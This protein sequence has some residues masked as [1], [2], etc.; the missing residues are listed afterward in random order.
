MTA[1]NRDHGTD[2][3]MPR[4]VTTSL[5]KLTET[6][7]EPDSPLFDRVDSIIEQGRAFVAAQ[8]NL[9]HTLTFW[10]V[11]H[12]INEDVLRH[13][14]ADYGKQVVETLSRQ[15]VAKRG[16]S[17]E[18]R[19]LRRMIQFARTFPNEQIVTSLMTQLSWTH[20]LQLLPLKTDEARLFYAEHAI[21]NHLNVR[22]LVSA[23]EGKAYERREIANAHIGVGSSVPLDTFRDPYLFDFLSLHEGY[24]EHD[25]ES[26][27]VHDMQAFLLE[28]GRGWA[29]V[30]R[31]KRIIV[32]GV[33]HY[34]DLLFFARPLRRLIAVELKVGRFQAA[35]K[36][37][38][39]LYLKWL[40]RYE[41]QEGENPPIGL[42]L[43]TGAGREEVELL[44]VHKDGIVVAEYWTTLPPKE[45]L[46]EHLQLI[47]RQ[48]TERMARRQVD[49]GFQPATR[50]T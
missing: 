20:F 31:Q 22:E 47:L 5:A 49:A 27:I 43:C 9:G 46:E 13:E 15:L 38:M 10:R 23:I 30:S 28:V 14:R 33:D 45:E 2:Q 26:A 42:I 24:Q 37:Q 16:R 7:A 44:E 21:T 41:R 36:G 50:T 35:Y 48:A 40:D 18:A 4:F 12:E 17:Y 39:E 11:G 6:D 34:I 25:L 29:F 3:G 32:D 19:N 8:A 1:Q